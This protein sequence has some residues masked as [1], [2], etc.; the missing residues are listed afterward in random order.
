MRKLLLK[1]ILATILVCAGAF[2]AAAGEDS[3]IGTVVGAGLGGW[4]GS[5]IGRGT[6]R[7]AATGAGVF[8]GGALGNSIGSSMDRAN[9]GYGG[10]AYASPYYDQPTVYE[11]NYVAPYAPPPPSVVY[12][13]PEVVYKQADNVYVSGGYVGDYDATPDAD[14]HFCREYTQETRINGTIQE[15][16]GTACL[17]PDGTWKIER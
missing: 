13:Q 9:G 10:Y 4:A 11:P 3:L 17:Q 8:L 2:P 5:S 15:S 7:L 12:L 6:G 1:A 14:T 16:Y